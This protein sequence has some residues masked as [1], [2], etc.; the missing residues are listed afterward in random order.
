[1]GKYS[2]NIHGDIC[3]SSFISLVEDLLA[4]DFLSGVLN[5]LFDG[6][7]GGLQELLLLELHL[8]LHLLSLHIGDEERRNEV[9][10]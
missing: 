6:L 10:D 9:L 4:V 2:S 3:A 5:S 1:M 7:L 8:L